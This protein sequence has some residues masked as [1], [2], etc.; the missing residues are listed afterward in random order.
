MITPS[1]FIPLKDSI[2]GKLPLLRRGPGEI[3]VHELY[4]S[5]AEKFEGIDEFLF[6][7]DVL[8]LLDKIDINFERGVVN[9]VE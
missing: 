9:Y 4:M 3:S 8:Y 6:A 5:V 1:K 2:I 7:V